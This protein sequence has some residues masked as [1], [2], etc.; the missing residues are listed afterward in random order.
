M[1]AHV[2]RIQYLKDV[3]Q[4]IKAPVFVVG[5]FRS[6]TT[7]LHRLLALD[8]ALP[9][10]LIWELAPPPPV[11]ASTG[12]D[13]LKR[14]RLALRDKIAEEAPAANEIG[15]WA[16][17]DIMHKVDTDL[18]EECQVSVGNIVPVAVVPFFYASIG[19]WKIYNYGLPTRTT[20]SYCRCWHTMTTL[21][22]LTP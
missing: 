19:R 20:R 5:L 15:D 17:F 2:L 16:R 21:L 12:A 8:P 14:K 9:S 11:S 3:Q 13:D 18:P 6:G 7:N 22:V 1:V 4:E 10:L